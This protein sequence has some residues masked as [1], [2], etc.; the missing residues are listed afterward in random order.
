MR[1]QQRQ[2]PWGR[3]SLGVLYGT[4]RGQCI[5]SH[6]SKGR[7]I[8]MTLYTKEETLDFIQSLIGAMQMLQEEGW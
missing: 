4:V 8:F 1:A 3:N 6:V 7:S 2:K 5:W